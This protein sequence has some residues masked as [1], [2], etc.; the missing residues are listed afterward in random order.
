MH[1][2]F[3]FRRHFPYACSKDDFSQELTWLESH[4][5]ID[6]VILSGGDPLAMPERDLEDLLDAIDS[7]QHIK[8]IRFHTRFPI[9]IP[10]R[11]DDRF[12]MSLQKLRKRLVFV[13]HVNHQK[14]I[15]D[16]VR[17]GFSRLSHLGIPLLSQT[18]LLR[19][20][21]DSDD[22]LE[23]LMSVLGDL[24]VIPYYLHQLDR[25]EGAS[26]FEVSLQKGM[27]LVKSLHKRLPGYLVPRY[28][29]EIPGEEGK[30]IFPTFSP[31]PE[32]LKDP[33][34]FESSPL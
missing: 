22:V 29:R 7:I 16:E 20:V 11:I 30:K 2:R 25:V 14:E 12:V 31:A 17:K 3:C 24:G 32:F 26:H 23:S 34:P 5:D 10:E 4:P 6:E 28:S 13:V 9:G 21:N 1:C 8:R 33:I 19:G 27:G 18:V 15:D